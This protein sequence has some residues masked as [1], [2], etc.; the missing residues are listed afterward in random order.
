[1]PLCKDDIMGVCLDMKH[2]KNKSRGPNEEWH[3]RILDV[4]VRGVCVEFLGH[5]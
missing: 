2:F 4:R 1:M 5:M 3:Y